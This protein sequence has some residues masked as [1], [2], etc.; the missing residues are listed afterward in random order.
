MR[1]YDTT[2]HLAL[3]IA[4]PLENVR[5]DLRAFSKIHPTFEMLFTL[6]ATAK[7]LKDLRDTQLSIGVSNW[8]LL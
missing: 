2:K 4:K 6:S 8:G 7:F 1:Y 3:D 5:K